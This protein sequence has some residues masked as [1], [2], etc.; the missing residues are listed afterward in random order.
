MTG[1]SG[2]GTT[3]NR[4]VVSRGNETSQALDLPVF[5]FMLICCATLES[6]LRYVKSYVAKIRYIQIGLEICI[7]LPKMTTKTE[8][9]F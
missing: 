7:L 2:R 4:S 3:S 8:K 9:N 6:V 1:N 5:E